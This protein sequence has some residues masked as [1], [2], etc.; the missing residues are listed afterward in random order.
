MHS[1]VEHWGP[2]L[3]IF[4]WKS[5]NLFWRF[6]FMLELFKTLILRFFL[7]GFCCISFWAK[8]WFKSFS[9]LLEFFCELKWTYQY[10]PCF[11][12]ALSDWIVCYLLKPM[13]LVFRAS[14]LFLEKQLLVYLT[15]MSHK[16]WACYD[17]RK[18]TKTCD[19]LWGKV[20]K[21]RCFIC[22]NSLTLAFI[23]FNELGRNKSLN[24]WC[25]FCI[26]S[27]GDLYFL[28][29][30]NSKLLNSSILFSS[31]ILQYVIKTI[32]LFR[33]HYKRVIPFN[34]WLEIPIDS[35]FIQRIKFKF[36]L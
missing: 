3:R 29:Y 15:M 4:R 9:S 8:N 34:K 25:N 12:L 1:K 16:R 17:G 19:C 10:W 32:K 27:D 23:L 6:G 14:R 20:G 7:W 36:I 28:Y 30:R 11:W 13:F 24:P 26:H 2:L 21:S 5:V 35:E 22:L 18:F 33:K 31:Y